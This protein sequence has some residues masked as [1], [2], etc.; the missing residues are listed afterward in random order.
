[1]KALFIIQDER[2]PSSRVR[3]LNLLPELENE[4]ISAEVIKYPKGTVGKIGL[5]KRSRQFDITYLQK[6]LLS[7]ID[8]TLLRRY[9]KRL[10][11][12]F[13]DAVYCRHD[14]QEVIESRTRLLKFKYLVGKADLVIAGNRILSD[15]ASQ[16]NQNV[17]VIPSA[18][19]T[20]NI[21]MKDYENL[22]DRTIIGWVGGEVNLHH[23][24][25]LSNTVLPR[26]A[27]EYRIQLRILSSKAI[28]VPPVEVKFIPWRLR[29]QEKEIALFDIGVMPL[30]DNRHTEGKCGYKVLQ[31]MAAGVPPVCSDV[32]INRDI[33]ENGKEGFV[34]QSIEGFYEAIKILIENRDL[35]KEMGIN[36]RK[37]VEE[38]YSIPVV[39]KR[40]ADILKSNFH[41]SN[42]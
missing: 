29:T 18:V 39:G 3:V 5:I 33:V 21:P 9:A 27:L 7:P 31:Y 15:Y 25:L 24:R 11:F 14:E 37:K 28:D 10:V 22:S 26:L 12:D 36:A 13:D 35:R 2:M 17:A 8:V 6:K 30:P 40:L 41:V 20:R 32:G 38:H 4:G 23:L 16:F 19:E 34:V 1:M 42:G